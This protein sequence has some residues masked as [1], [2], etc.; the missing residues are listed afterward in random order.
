MRISILAKEVKDTTLQCVADAISVL[1]RSN[2]GFVK[3]AK[4]SAISYTYLRSGFSENI[5][6]QSYGAAFVI[7]DL[8]KIYSSKSFAV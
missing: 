4:K 7:L 2:C 6:S 3:T 5:V 1:M 8:W